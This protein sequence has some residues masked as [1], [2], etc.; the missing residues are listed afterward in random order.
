MLK[1]PHIQCIMPVFLFC[2][3]KK[4]N[5]KKTNT[6]TSVL[7]STLAPGGGGVPAANHYGFAP[8]A[9]YAAVPKN[10]FSAAARLLA[11]VTARKEFRAKVTPE[12]VQSFP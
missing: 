9:K 11:S 2:L 8:Q 5:K 12:D 3:K 7:S 6:G 4:N 1:H 10:L